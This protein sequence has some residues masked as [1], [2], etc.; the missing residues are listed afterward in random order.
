MTYQGAGF[1]GPEPPPVLAAFAGPLPQ[2]RGSVAVRWILAIPAVVVLLA[3]GLVGLVVGVLGWFAAL[4]TGRLPQFAYDYLTGQL[5][6][7]V[8]VNAYL[9]LLTDAYPRFSF[10][11]VDYPVR[12][13]VPP[14]Q[15]LNRLAVLF[16][17]IIAFP[18]AVVSNVLTQGFYFFICVI[19]WIVVLI[20]AQ[21][22]DAI[23]RALA[24]SLRYQTRLGGYLTMLTAAY[25]WGLYGDR[26]LAGFGPAVPAGWPP[27]PPPSPGPSWPTPPPPPPFGASAP[28]P[29]PPPFGHPPA[30]TIPG[31]SA[32][33]DFGAP[34]QMPAEG[35]TLEGTTYL[36]GYTGGRGYV[37]I[38][39]RQDPSGPGQ[40]WPMAEQG[41]AWRHFRELEPDP[42]DYAGPP[43]GPTA[44]PGTAAPGAP[45]W[46][47]APPPPPPPWTAAAAPTGLPRYPSEPHPAYRTAPPSPES[48]AWP[49]WPPGPPG[50]YPA[51]GAD[52][53]WRLEVF[54]GA[55]TFLTVLV[56][57][58]VVAN[59]LSPP[60]TS[61]SSQSVAAPAVTAPP[62]AGHRAHP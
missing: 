12:V 47:G 53:A 16:R 27:P 10:G 20:E 45:S 50:A 6:V 25:P 8:R 39:A 17:L 31:P 36:W 24:A 30:G 35:F 46:L 28:P 7:S 54:G 21:P 15:P 5:R 26:P 33:P 14:P 49:A 62:A 42:V 44:W 38:W 41:E 37:G 57:W 48:G 23:Y 22:P 29:V 19:V 34:L 13:A 3:I 1:S 60:A 4:V 9:L 55:R 2:S 61:T 43:P 58:G 56:V 52:P 32:V 51:D 40:V 11:D 59:L 18:A